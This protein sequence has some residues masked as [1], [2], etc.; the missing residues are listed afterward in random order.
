MDIVLVAGLWLDASAWDA[1][2]GELEQ[3]G[4]RA[5]PVTLPGQ[6]DGR[7]GATLDDQV[8]AVVAAVDAAVQSGG[9]SGGGRPLVVGH[10][11]ACSL[12]W[13]A[14]DARVD[15]V[16]GTALI[17]GW[18]S[19]DGEKYAAFFDLTDG[20]MPFPGWEPFEGPD[21]ADLDD[22][23]KE[24]VAAAAIPVP[25]EVAHG[26]VRLTDPRR[27][28][29]PTVLVCPEYTPAEAK[30]WIDAG[31]LPELTQVT[32]LEMVDL[33]SG[34]WP[35]FSR[36]AELAQVLAEIADRLG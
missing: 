15:Q 3:R 9:E 22:A 8:A 21:S 23:T 34:H 11:A 35:M 27:Y 4:H 14:A 29:V 12:A 1:V 2:V 33:D 32:R 36:P 7:A 28:D 24:R 18:P 16:A 30:E 20:V 5:R 17:G 19:P 25:G 26:V 13:L 31:D 6:G 10:S